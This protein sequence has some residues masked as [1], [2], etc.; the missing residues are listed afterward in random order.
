MHKLVSTGGW[1]DEVVRGLCAEL[2]TESYPSENPKVV[3]REMLC[4]TI[5]TALRSADARDL[6]RATELIDLAAA[7]TEE[8]LRITCHLSRRLHGANG[9]VGR[10]PG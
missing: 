2:P 8:H 3:V 6:Q 7:R 4:G 9:S 10:T 5:G 1:L